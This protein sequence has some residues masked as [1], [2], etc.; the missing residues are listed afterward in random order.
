MTSN[1]L[2]DILRKIPGGYVYSG[3]CSYQI[4]F[5][6]KSGGE[7][8]FAEYED[9]SPNGVSFGIDHYG[10]ELPPGITGY[11]ESTGLAK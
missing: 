10:G 8:R 6:L 4:C 2:F 1:E 9:D 11:A 7:L 3:V 5:P